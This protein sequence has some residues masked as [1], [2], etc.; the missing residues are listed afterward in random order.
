MRT[1]PLLLGALATASLLTSAP[2]L[3]GVQLDTLSPAPAWAQQA[4]HGT[5]QL[6]A[7]QPELAQAI[8]GAEA[9]P[10]RSGQPVFIEPAWRAPEAAPALLVRIAEGD[11][12]A[13]EK[14]GLLDAL[15]RNSGDWAEGVLGLAQHESDPMVRRMMIEIL[16]HAPLEVAEAGVQ[17]GLADASIEVR[18]AAARVVGSHPQGATMGALLLGGLQDA[19]PVVREESARSIGY[20]G[21]VPAF[22]ATRSLLTDTD[23]TVRYRALRSLEKLDSDRTAKLPEL[24]RL[25]VDADPKVARQA[26]ELQAR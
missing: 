21:Y 7:A 5:A 23:A 25:V 17:L 6:E 16:R 8:A 18:A 26:Q 14:I 13:Q 3:A 24:Q 9:R 20:A 1:P 4:L 22:D 19:S 15:S 2:A 11:D 10:S 12:T